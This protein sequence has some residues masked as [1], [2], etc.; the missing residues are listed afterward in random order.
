MRSGA[1]SGDYQTN[2]KRT[3]T[4]SLSGRADPHELTPGGER[5]GTEDDRREG[6]RKDW[7]AGWIGRGW[8]GVCVCSQATQVSPRAT[9]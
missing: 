8:D 9:R 1:D 2:R 3:G 6:E 4:N 5:E 7:L